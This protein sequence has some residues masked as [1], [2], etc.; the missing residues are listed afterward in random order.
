M[1]YKNW[2][3][4]LLCMTSTW[5]LA[6]DATEA[7]VKW[8]FKL[9][10]TFYATAQSHN[11]LDINLRGNNGPHAVWIGQYQRGNAFEQTRVGYEFTAHYDWGQ[12]VPSVQAATAGFTGGS[13]TVQVGQPVYVMAGFGRTNLRDYYNL[14]FDPNDMVTFGLGA[15]LAQDHQLSV[16]TVKDNRLGTGQVITH[17]VWRWQANEAERWTVDLAY[18]E[19][20]SSPGEPR[21]SGR[22]A[23]VTYDYRQTF[24]RLACDENVNFSANN[25][26][27]VSAG[28]RF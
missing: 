5:A 6:L 21:V 23:S 1:V 17:V 28:L 2:L 27:R 3:S 16:F 22:S 14:N 19:G 10:P 24:L 8:A 7:P 26:T 13:L 25:Q 20:S 18:K 11:A 4:T 9:T 15:K 12:M